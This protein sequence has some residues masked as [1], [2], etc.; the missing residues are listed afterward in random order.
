MFSGAQFSISVMSDDFADVILG[1][2]RAVGEPE[3]VRME[4][5]ELS[6]LVVGPPK[7]VIEVIQQC[8]AEACRRGG[9]VTLNALLSRGC[10]GEPDDPICTPQEPEGGVIPDPESVAELGIPVSAQ[11]SLYPMGLSDHMGV[12]FSE[13]ERAQATSVYEKGKHFCT[14]LRGD[15]ARVLACVSACYEGA[16]SQAGHVVIHLSVSKGSPS[17]SA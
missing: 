16:A 1:A 10:P 9:H 12:V 7:R 4:T 6:T 3:D 13:I 17:E 14:K 15:L 5:D 11:F 8:Y 2:I